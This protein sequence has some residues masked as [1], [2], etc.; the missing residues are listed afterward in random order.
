MC[1]SRRGYNPF[2]FAWV[3]KPGESLETPKFYGGYT[4]HGDGEA[5]RILHRFQL[6][7]ILPARPDPRPRP[8]IYNSW[9]ATG[10]NVDEPGQISLAEK[11]ATIGVE[12]FVIG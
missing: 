3:L 10:F 12:R 9:E 1:G 11:A 5:S 7:E 4:R 6:A 8:I 2:D